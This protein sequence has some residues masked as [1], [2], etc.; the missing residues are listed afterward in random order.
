MSLFLIRKYEFTNV[1]Q[2]VSKM[3]DMGGAGGSAAT[4]SIQQYCLKWNNH[5][6]FAI[7]IIN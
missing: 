3:V 1:F 7:P 2:K 6:V 5:Q 4:P